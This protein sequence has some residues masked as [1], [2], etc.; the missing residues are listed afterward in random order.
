M[1]HLLSD[2]KPIRGKG[3]PA[4][5]SLSF[6]R[7]CPGECEGCAD[8][9]KE[10]DRTMTR[11]SLA[12]ALTAA[13]VPATAPAQTVPV[14]L[15]PDGALLDVV[16]E[17]RTTRTPDLAI[18]NAGVV[19]QAE[20]AAA[21][22]AA[23]ADRMTRVLAALRGAGI[24]ARDIQTATIALNPQYRY[25]EN[26]PPVITG[27]QANNRVTV[28]F[29]DVAKSGAIL[30]ALVGEGANQIDGPSLT[31]A[32]PDAALDEARAD[33]V[34]RARSRADLYARA[35]GMRV[36]RIAMIAEGGAVAG[37]S[38]PMPVMMAREA[39]APKT[40]VEAGEQDV[41]ATV[42]VRFVLR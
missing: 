6:R 16:A 21:A 22:L 13:A 11:L 1:L 26:V 40:S 34:A 17:G 19:T 35:A 10:D 36:V 4:H 7:S 9:F 42:T 3:R 29:R 33:A 27:Y 38:M 31:L 39:S 32:Q 23:N 8:P 2:R 14:P 24:A 37:P 41:T 25:G 15:L 30:D 5:A 12:L 20:T 28:R 18:I